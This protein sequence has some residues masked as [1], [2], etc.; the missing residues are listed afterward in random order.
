MRHTPWAIP[1]HRKYY[2]VS[3]RFSR[4]TLLPAQRRRILH[5]TDKFKVFNNRSAL[6]A[7]PCA[8]SFILLP[9]T[10]LL[11]PFAFGQAPNVSIILTTSVNPL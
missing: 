1:R 10:F 8:L 7:T 2:F 3:K 9:L 6:S 4:E 5:L 11:L